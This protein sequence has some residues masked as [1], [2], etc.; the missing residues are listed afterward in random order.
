MHDLP[1]RAFQVS[2]LP[3]GFL[4]ELVAEKITEANSH[5]RAKWRL[6]QD[7]AYHSEL[8]GMILVPMGFETDFASVPRAPLAFWLT[9]DT[10]HKSATVHDYLVRV[11]YP[12]AKISWRLAADVFGEA[13]KHEGVKGWRRWLMRNAVIGADPANKQGPYE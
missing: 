3:H 10:A 2:T 4:T 8:Y 7:L 13:M 11:H 6:R 12:Q 9:G 1:Q 5:G